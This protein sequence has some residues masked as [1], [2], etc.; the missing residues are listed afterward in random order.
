[1]SFIG[2]LYSILQERKRDKTVFGGALI[3]ELAERQKNEKTRK[4]SA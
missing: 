1:M 4:R 3:G 2:I